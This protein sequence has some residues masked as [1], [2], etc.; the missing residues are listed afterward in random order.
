MVPTP[1][2][3]R[4]L[5]LLRRQP[6]WLLPPRRAASFRAAAMCESARSADGS[7]ACG[8]PH[9]HL[10]HLLPRPHPP[11]PPPAPGSLRPCRR[12]VTTTA[13]TPTTTFTTTMAPCR[14]RVSHHHLLQSQ[15]TELTVTG[16]GGW[17]AHSGPIPNRRHR[18]GHC[19]LPRRRHDR[20]QIYWGDTTERR[21]AVWAVIRGVKGHGF[22]PSVNLTFCP[23]NT[24]QTGS[25][26]GWKKPF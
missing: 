15:Q 16:A 17:G 6:W 23:N 4:R 12:Q 8:R 2:P 20:R 11:P 19:P 3:A 26:G 9:S 5:P 1:P 21:D 13:T 18:P 24:V 22:K 14:C 7:R 10:P 25:R